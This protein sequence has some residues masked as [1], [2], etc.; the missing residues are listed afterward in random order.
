MK[1]FIENKI[2]FNYFAFLILLFC[3]SFLIRI[4]GIDWDNGFLFHPDERA[5]FMHAYDLSF[6]SF[7]NGFEVFNAEKSS[8]NPKW[9]NYGSFPLYFLKIT[10]IVI[11]IF[12]DLNIFELRIPA[13]ILS[14]F[15]DSLSVIFITIIASNFIDKKSSLLVGILA[16]ISLINIQNSHFFTTDVFVT[17]ISLLIILFSFKNSEKT[18]FLRTLLLSLFFA[19]GLSFKFS[20]LPSIFP[21]L[22][23][24]ILLYLNNKISLLLLFKY[25]CIFLLFVIFFLLIF[26]PYMFFDFH[27]Y[28]SNILEQSKMVRG[29]HDFPYTRQYIN[30]TNF[31]YP[32][33]QIVK[34]GIGPY[35][36]IISIL[37]FFY[38]IF[39]SIKN[40]SRLSFIILIW[41]VPYLVINGSFDVK[42]T[43]YFLPLIPFLF[44][45]S[46][47]FLK[48][49]YGYIIKI[50]PSISKFKYFIL[51]IFI[52]PTLHFS[53]SYINGI[54]LTEHP[55]VLASKWLELNAEE[56]TLI[57]QD[58]WEESIPAIEGIKFSH[59]RLELYNPDSYEKFDKI[60]T[61]LSQS[62]YY[63]IFSN[64]L[65]GT[66][67]RL[68]KRYPVS[69]NFYERIF[70]ETLG[71]KIVN[72]EKQSMNLFSINYQ[73]NY[74]QR[75]AIQKPSNINNYENDFL[76]NLNL[77]W[78][79]ESFSVY[80]H[81]NVI[82]LKNEK[83][84]S[85]DKLFEILDQNLFEKTKS[86]DFTN[87]ELYKKYENFG[88]YGE[89]NLFKNQMFLDDKPILLQVFFWFLMINFL[90]I[91]FMP[92]FYKLFINFPE[93][94]YSFYKFFGLL[95]FS[96][97]VW[98]F[99][100][101]GLIDF[102]FINIFFI[103]LILSIF[104]IV[105][106]VKNKKEILY[107]SKKSFKQILFVEF[108][109]FTFFLLGILIRYL[110]PDLWHPYRGGEKPMDLAFLNSIIRSTSFPPYD[111][112]FSGYTLNYYYFGHFMV[113][114]ASKFTGIPSYI[115]Y[116]LAIP[117]FFAYSATL[118]FGFSSS[119]VYLFRKSKGLKFDWFK[120]PLYTGI[121][122]VFAILI[123]GNFDAVIQ[124]F[125][126]I[127]N[128]QE[129]FDYWRS[130]RIISMNSSG[131]EINE[132][133]FFSFL[134]ADL[135]AHLMSIPLI[136]SL[137]SVSFI[138]F[139]EFSSNNSKVKNLLILLFLSLITGA[140]KATNTWDYPLGLII[141]FFS[142]LFSTFLSEGK[143]NIRLIRFVLYFSFYYLMS[144]FL[145]YNFENNF[146]MPEFGL[147]F[148]KWKTSSII[149]LEILFVPIILSSI[150]ISIYTYSLKLKIQYLKFNFFS[151]KIFMFV[152]IIF[153]LF[154]LF[155]FFQLTSIFLLSTLLI[156]ILIIS[157]LK[158]KLFESDSRLFLWIA[159]LLIIGFGIP[160]LTDI[161]V[162]NGD[163]NRMNTVFKF[164]FQSWIILNLGASLLI[165]LIFQEIS[166]T[167]IK[168]I[169]FSSILILFI[170]GMIYPIYSIKPR[171]L[172]RFSNN[173]FGL[174]GNQY[175]LSSIYLYK[176][177]AIKLSNTYDAVNWINSNIQGN[178][179]I[180]ENSGELYTWSSAI[181]INTGLPSVLGWDWHEKQQRSLN[182]YSITIRNKQIEEFYTTSSE[183]F[184][185]DF[186]D[187]YSV[188]LVIFGP[189][190][191]LNYPDFDKR[192]KFIMKS[193]VI[194]IYNNNGYIIFKYLKKMENNE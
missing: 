176:D 153:L 159:I 52:L 59:E 163:I 109:F 161:F 140:I 6:D 42:F 38:F 69:T 120:T 80:D 136:I 90:G 82:I 5:I 37:G 162:V 93:F 111:P 191:K 115:S 34:W 141:V 124:V 170:F 2:P 1:F 98:F 68:D 44:L 60:F 19:L 122:S 74:F 16:S 13:R 110:N 50:Y 56:N 107:Y 84:Y 186:L 175:M 66:I 118:I 121:F 28:V 62:D 78:S 10:T 150:F 39:Y 127:F 139:Y 143:I 76:I 158:L 51:I 171:L 48:S 55:A 63:V 97:I 33:I 101:Y 29:I 21:I 123:F 104:S 45:F 94:G 184:I 86:F 85:K 155:L 117:T 188:E 9:F 11:N 183:Q 18:S 181:S 79:D 185:K 129:T 15:I 165:P 189:V 26:Q 135:H 67:P 87:E 152:L 169:F 58:H 73:E 180:V 99:V 194:E 75:I 146:I 164:N 40:K 3:F 178:P 106:F 177:N 57:V 126:I 179:I 144:S 151:K 23:S 7:K 53:L 46:V 112:W 157:I 24:Y 25:L 88:D 147:S 103:A 4:V 12:Y 83:K 132:F 156:S 95:S 174:E 138:F 114:L 92:I 149:M 130:T 133:P 134:F 137:V 64:R 166:S 100:S 172:D 119:F 54:Y 145:F 108:L 70:D 36:G 116:N 105:L 128:F 61:L 72:F 102:I 125:N 77:G 131:L 8:F 30:T 193:E 65:Y 47:L 49:I 71:F 113:G 31:L 192:F 91:L 14:V 22:F 96:F 27:T 173:Y 81:P 160:I 182:S 154:L 89:I 187:Y 167:K 142:I 32:I 41:F 43:R 17:N 190:E 35:L 20:F 168:R 148:S